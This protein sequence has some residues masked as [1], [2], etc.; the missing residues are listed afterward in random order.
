VGS[1][2]VQDMAVT[3][4]LLLPERFEHLKV[5]TTTLAMSTH[6]AVLQGRTLAR[7]SQA[8]S[9]DGAV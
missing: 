7:D 1:E 5:V 4:T 8:F 2:D 3:E 6:S 9:I